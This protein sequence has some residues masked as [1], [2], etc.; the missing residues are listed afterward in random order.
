VGTLLLLAAAVPIMSGL[1]G[2]NTHE[3]R[4]LIQRIFTLAI[5]P[6]IGVAA[7]TFARWLGTQQSRH[8]PVRTASA[9]E[10]A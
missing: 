7:W 6:P 9:A 10:P 2:L 1:S 8:E 5:F 4:G 3:Y